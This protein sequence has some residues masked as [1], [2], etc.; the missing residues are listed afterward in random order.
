MKFKVLIFAVIAIAAGV[1]AWIGF[2]NHFNQDQIANA[3]VPRSEFQAAQGIKGAQ[4]YYRTI[5][6]NIYTG[7]IEIEDFLNAK[8]AIGLMDKSTTG[9]AKNSDVNWA[10]MGP[11]NVGGRTRAILPFRN[12]V[13]TLIAGGVSGGL[14]KTTDAGQNWIKIPSFEDNLVVSSIAMLGNGAIYVGTG[15][16]REGI[17]ANKSSGFMGGGLF[18]STDNGNTWNLVNDFEPTPFVPNSQWGYINKIVAD[19]SNP[20]RLWIGTNFGLFAFIHGSPELEDMSV[21]LTGG[22]VKDLAISKDGQNIITAIGARIYV[23]RDYGATFEQ[24]N[25]P[26]SYLSL[27]GSGFGA[28]DFDVSPDDKNFM[29]ACMPTGSGSLLGIFATRDAGVTWN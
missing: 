12:D 2:N 11:D 5:K 23:S 7:E 16:S 15:H 14:F 19:G 20:D 6:S 8:R 17:S 27:N 18:V 13:N 25:G 29:V 22:G 21:G 4:E 9:M 10:S 24:V 28:I 3:Y 26:G 1:V